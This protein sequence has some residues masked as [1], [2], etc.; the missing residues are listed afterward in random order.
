MENRNGPK[1]NQYLLGRD[2]TIMNHAI[3]FDIFRSDS[4]FQ[5]THKR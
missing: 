1:I 2:G 4:Q 3:D 5:F